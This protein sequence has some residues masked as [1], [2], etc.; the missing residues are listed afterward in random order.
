[1]TVTVED[2]AS[3]PYF[4]NGVTTQFPFDFNAASVDEV[5][6]ILLASSGAVYTYPLGTYAVVLAV[7]G[8][9]GTVTMQTAPANDG[10]ALFVVSD[11]SF[12]QE[13]LFEDEGPFN[14]AVLNPVADRSA[15]RDLWLKSRVVRSIQL[16]PGEEGGVLPSAALRGGGGQG[17]I[18]GFNAAGGLRLHPIAGL[19]IAPPASLVTTDTAGLSVQDVLTQHETLSRLAVPARAGAISMIQRPLIEKVRELPLNPKDFGAVWNGIADDYGPM[20]ACIIEAQNTGKPIQLP[21]GNCRTTHGWSVTNE[22]RMHGAVTGSDFG[23]TFL[24]DI[25]DPAQ[26]VFSIGPPVGGSII[27]LDMGYFNVSTPGNYNDGYG[28]GNTAFYITTPAGYTIHNSEWHHIRVL[29]HKTGFSFGGVFYQNAFRQLFVTSSPTFNTPMRQPLN[30]FTTNVFYDVT[31]NSF[32]TLEVTNV[33]NGGYAYNMSSHWSDFTQ[34][35]FDGPLYINSPGGTARN[36][37]CEAWTPQPGTSPQS[38]VMNFTNLARMESIAIRAVPTTKAGIGLFI[39]GTGWVLEGLNINPGSP[40]N[41][42]SGQP[43]TPLYLDGRGLIIGGVATGVVNKLQATGDGQLNGTTV[44]NAEAFTD[45]GI[46][47]SRALRASGDK[48]GFYGK[49]P[50]DKPT[51]VAVDAAGI[52]AALVNLGLIAA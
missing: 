45:F 7:D 42:E 20:Q 22:I 8:E 16:P 4:P 14:S 39:G 3:G 19:T 43:N 26:S 25:A 1:M 9:G 15:I 41:P 36:I 38:M 23:T 31:Y 50:V 10:R 11:P 44:I 33:G 49:A 13:I 21:A 46:T 2:A 34:L 32:H 28:Y 35:T 6:V 27:G 5:A 48:L 40:G 24:A 18:L 51:G 30:G 37:T 47:T 52:H 12:A 29:N 17:S